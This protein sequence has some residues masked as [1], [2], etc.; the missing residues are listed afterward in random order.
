MSDLPWI[1]GGDYNEILS[2]KEKEGGPLRSNFLIEAFRAALLDCALTEVS[3][4]GERFTWTNNRKAPYT[5]RCR[6]DS[7]CTNSAWSASSRT[8]WWS[9]S[10]FRVRTI[11]PSCSTLKN[12]V[13]FCEFCWAD[14]ETGTHILFHCPYFS[15]IWLEE[16]FNITHPIIAS[17]FATGLINLRKMV[18]EELFLLACV[19]LWNVWNFRNGVLHDS[20][21]G[22]RSTIVARSKDFLD[23]Y[24]SAIF[25]FPIRS[26]APPI[27]PW[28]PPPAPFIKINFNAGFPTSTSHQIAAVARDSDHCCVG[29]AVRRLQG[30][31]AP[32]VAEACAARFAIHMT[33]EKGW[34]HVHLEGDCLQVINTFKDGK[35]HGLSEFEV[36]VSASIGLASRFSNFACFFIRR[37]SNCLAHV[38]SHIVLLDTCSLDGVSIPAD[39]ARLI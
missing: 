9:I 17:N 1:I 23:S 34:T 5:V 31:P 24:S 29:W 37:L 22:E 2:N 21:Q 7:V 28:Q 25:T 38:F 39:L 30:S 18:S 14:L 10:H 3:F 13:K 35:S 11:Y 27:R 32:V 20:A 4:T 19:V 15:S 12:R 26:P 6:L 33:L 8:R 36:I 16:P